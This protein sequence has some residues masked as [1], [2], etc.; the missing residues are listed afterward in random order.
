[1]KR[2]LHIGCGLKPY[3]AK[4][5]E[6]VIH[7]DIKEL[8]DVEIVADLNNGIP[9]PSNSFD[10]VI[11][12]DIVEHIIDVIKLMEEIH[13]VL[14]KGGVVKIHTTYIGTE[15]SFA[16]PTHFHYFTLNSFDYFD[17]DTSFGKTYSFYSK[18]KFKIIKKEIKG[19]WLYFELKK[20]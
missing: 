11:A 9:L 15:M 8:P 1:M 3:K 18:A 13:R 6:E 4:E 20:I 12:D 19:G 10:E 14:K 17:P 7:L 2:I 16:D 5:N